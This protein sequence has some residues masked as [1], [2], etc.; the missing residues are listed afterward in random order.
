MNVYLHGPSQI[1]LLGET[2]GDNLRRTVECFGDRDALVVR[3]QNYR[4]TY[5]QLWDSTTIL[6][7]ALL[8][9]GVRQGDRVGIWAPN[10]FEWVLT[11][12]ATARIGAILV[13]I[14]PAYKASELRYALV[15]SGTSLLIHAKRSGRAT[16][17]R[18]SRKCGPTAPRCGKPSRSTLTGWHCSN[19]HTPRRTA[20]SRS[21][22][23]SCSSTTPSTSSTRPARR[24]I[25][26]G[27]TLSHHNIL[28]NGFLVG[29]TIK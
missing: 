3:S 6:A 23:R 28:N 19:G 12:F 20:S 15:Q 4:A 22:S 11:Q 24:A 27:A 18:W 10:R 5:R 29:E 1:P 21:A 9:S 13:N 14:N 17:C 7:R 25:R 16:M 2:I 8:A 26:K